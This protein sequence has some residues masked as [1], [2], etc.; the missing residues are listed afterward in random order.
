MAGQL[1]AGGPQAGVPGVGFVLYGIH[2]GLP[3]L[4]AHAHGEWFLFHGRPRRVQHGEGVP[5][6]VPRRQDH[7]PGWQGVR[8]LWAGHVHGGQTPVL[9]ADPVQPVTEANVRTVALELPAEILQGDVEIVGAH[10]G[11]GVGEDS[12]RRAAGH[13]PFQDPPVAQIPG[14]GVQ[15]SVGEGPGAAFAKLDVGLGVQRPAVPESLHI[16]DAPLRGLAP[17]Q[18]DGPSAAQG[19][20]QSGEETRRA[21]AHHDGPNLR[22]GDG[23]GQ[24][25][26][27]RLVDADPTIPAAPQDA[28]LVSHPDGQRIDQHRFLPGVHR[29]AQYLQGEDLLLRY[30]QQFGR[31]G[32]KAF[33]PPAGFP[34]DLIQTQHTGTSFNGLFTD[35]RGK[36]KDC[37]KVPCYDRRQKE[38]RSCRQPYDIIKRGGSQEKRR[39]LP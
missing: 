30:P 39:Q 22:R 34:F 25:V 21:G 6:A 26:E 20:D 1:I 16:P 11:L 15:F 17:L 32:P 24:S 7:L 12:V 33:L 13:H 29:P 19:Q 23:P 14:A 4:D 37:F 38:K 3:V 31:R 35:Y 8:P 28:L 2:V 36:L 27:L 10:V 5:G 18:Q 9:R